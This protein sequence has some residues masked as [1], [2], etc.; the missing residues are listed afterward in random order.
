MREGKVSLPNRGAPRQSGPKVP[1]GMA[2]IGLLACVALV[3]HELWFFS[4]HPAQTAHSNLRRTVQD[5]PF[6]YYVLKRSQGFVLARSRAGSRR[7]PLETPRAIAS[8]GNGFGRTAADAIVALQVSPDGRYMAIDGTRSDEE[9]VWIFDTRRLVLTLQPAGASGTFLHWLPAAGGIFL[10]RPMFPRGPDASLDGGNWKP[11]LWEVNAATGAI[12]ALDIHMPASFLIDA[13]PS[14]DGSQIIY[15]TSSGLGMG[16]DIWR[17]DAHGGR[18]VHLLQISAD[19]HSMAGLFAWSPG[20][21]SVAYE[22]LA[23]SPEPFLPAELW[24]MDAQGG[25]QRLLAPADGGHGFALSWSPDGQ[26]IA[27]V[28][29]TNP[30][31]NI[32]DQSMQALKSAIAV[33]DVQSKQVWTVAGPAQTGAQV[34]ADPIWN[35]GGAQITFAAFNPLNP[36][37]GGTVRYWT[38]NVPPAGVVPAAAPLA[39]AITHVVAF[40]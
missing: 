31:E 23:D 27:F 24:V 30:G 35:P 19:A 36:A 9:T 16:S 1:A 22:R 14:P 3:S 38:A 28:A 8:F 33:I 12:T 6:L 18:Q 11:G 2:L 26:K 15:S 29:R 20:G 17:M 7:Q 37:L 13:V 25:T 4:S 10:F 21:Q 34:S 5:G 39:P 40:V 32:A